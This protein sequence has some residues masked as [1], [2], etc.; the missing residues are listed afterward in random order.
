[1]TFRTLESSAAERIVQGWMNSSGHRR[2][3]LSTSFTHQ[4]I[5]VHIEGGRVYSTQKFAAPR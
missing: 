3:I 4:G 1:M 5:G 2:N